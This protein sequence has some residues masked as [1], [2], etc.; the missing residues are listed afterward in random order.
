MTRSLVTAPVSRYSLLLLLLSLLLLPLMIPNMHSSYFLVAL[1][2]FDFTVHLF[3]C[4]L[5]Q[6]PVLTVTPRRLPVPWA[7][8]AWRRDARSSLS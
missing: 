6:L 2:V 7:R 4:Y 3:S 1:V 8:S 5:S